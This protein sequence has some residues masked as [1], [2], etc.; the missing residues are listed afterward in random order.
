MQRAFA[1][2]LGLT[3][4][5]SQ[6]HAQ[7]EQ[8]AKTSNYEIPSDVVSS[9]GGDKAHSTNYLLDD[10][11]GE[12]NIGFG[13]S[14]NYDVNAG[15]RQ[16]DGGTYLA[17]ACD[18]PVVI[19]T[20][21]FTG[22]ATG[23]GTC[24]VT[25]DNE[26]G[27]SLSWNDAV[28]DGGS[29]T[30]TLISTTSHDV[31]PA[32]DASASGLV[33]YWRLDETSAGSTVIDASGNG[34][35]L[36]PN[37]T[38][39]T[40]NLPQPS[41]DLPS[42]MNVADTRSLNFDGTDDYLRRATF[43]GVPTSQMTICSWIKTSA[44]ATQYLLSINRNPTNIIN[45]GVFQMNAAGTLTFWDYNGSSFGFSQSNTSTTAVNDGA[46]H[47]ACFVKNGTS[48]TY[49]VDGQSDGTPTAALNIS[50]GS[51]DLVIGSNTRD[52]T[53]YFSGNMDDIR[54]YNRA[55]SAAEVQ[56]LYNTPHTWSVASTTSAWGA[57]LRSSSTDTDS[58]WGTDSSSEKW[59]NVG[60]GSY[61]VVTRSSRTSTGGSAEV[62]QY[63]AEVGAADSVPNNTYQST[64]T[65]TASA[66]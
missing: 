63:R 20:I 10:T 11:I 19:G 18:T 26:A 32:F 56:A 57:R 55:L 34:K 1:I 54:L 13:R 7:E 4:L 35:N 17:M 52:S 31:I 53:L 9:G 38:S 65:M 33:G 66:L 14:A 61:S 12:A 8:R 21:T 45:E 58:K 5:I 46:W 59:L 15:Y 50:Y 62:F 36:T 49:Y 22:Q 51:N 16:P 60:D 43:T 37:G 39:G 29:N 3:I 30:G 47:Q 23:N 2:L 28:S 24:T 25:T 42:N 64:V 48:G 27:Y 6:V 40:N 44:S 41:T